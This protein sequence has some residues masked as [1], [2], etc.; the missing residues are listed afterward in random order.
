MT[1]KPAYILGAGGHGKVVLR[2]LQQLGY[3]VKSIFDDDPSRIGRSLHGVPI[4]GPVALAGSLGRVPAVI[5]VGS[6][7][8]R[9][10]LAEQFDL[11]WLTLV[12]PAAFVDPTA[13]VGRGTVVLPGAVVHVDAS[14]GDHAIVNTRASIDHDCVIADFVHLAPGSTLAGDVHVGEGG[15]V[16]TGASV[17]PGVRVGSWATVGAGAVAVTSVPDDVIVKGVPARQREHSDPLSNGR[18]VSTQ[19]SAHR[20][21]GTSAPS[22]K[23]GA[24]S[25]PTKADGAP[26]P[27]IYLSPPHMGPQERELLLQ[28]FD[29][30]WIAPLG[31][32]VDAFEHEF[33]AQVGVEHA[34]ALSS[35]TAALHLALQVVGV[36]AGDEV[37]VPSLTF[38]ATANAVRYLGARPIFV[39]S[40]RASWNV[41]PQLVADELEDRVRQG[42]KPSAV[43]AVDVFGQ[44]ADYQLL[45]KTCQF[46]EIPVIEDAAEA[47]GASYHG[48][49][50]GSFGAIGC[51]SF[52][53]NKII[54]TSGGGMLVTGRKDWADHARHLASQ[55]K[56]P[57]PYYEHSEVG[58]NYRL[59]NLLAAVGRGQLQ[60]LEDRVASRRRIFQWYRE[61][62]GELPGIEFMP[63][64]AGTRSSRWLT[65]LLVDP[66]AFGATRESLRLALAA[67]NIEARPLWKPMHLQPVYRDFPMRGGAVAERLFRQGLCLPSGSSMSADDLERIRNIILELAPRTQ[68]LR[69]SASTKVAS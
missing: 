54:T 65:C 9:K 66:D 29:S 52:N 3:D 53:G 7:E 43:I 23:P 56:N 49:P 25:H 34:V 44:C 20:R 50:A 55:A 28:A 15:F 6:N 14:I 58:Y 27:R 62:L 38:I 17:I 59:S 24:V 8:A 21:R 26:P 2:L 12:H 47:L 19:L 37:L 36:G 10:R 35:G 13:D 39:D 51:F 11:D 69:L 63:E 46:Y 42:R 68:R 45:L 60:Q 67:E 57:K 31:P 30:N 18:G 64:L 32:E 1:I 16:G 61:H 22:A 41:D 48:R 4:L 40:D 5:G 33:A